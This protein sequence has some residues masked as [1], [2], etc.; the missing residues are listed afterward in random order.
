MRQGYL[1]SHLCLFSTVGSRTLVP[2][3]QFEDELD[4]LLFLFFPPNYGDE[5]DWTEFISEDFIGRP[6][7]F[8]FPSTW[9][10]WAG[11]DGSFDSRGAFRMR[12]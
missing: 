9:V 3:C 10:P 2:S 8:V 1:D 7:D 4:L 11:W 12:S 6:V 5:L